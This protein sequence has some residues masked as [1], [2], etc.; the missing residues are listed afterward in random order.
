MVLGADG[1]KVS[2]AD[3]HPGAIFLVQQAV[4]DRWA[5]TRVPRINANRTGNDRNSC[6]AWLVLVWPS[7]WCSTGFHFDEVCR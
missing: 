2:I 5:T 6:P 4:L 1:V 3:L 7:G